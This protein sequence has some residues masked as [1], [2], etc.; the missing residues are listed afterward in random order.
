MSK[1]K[2]SPEWILAR[3]RE[4]L[5]GKNTYRNIAKAHGIS[6]SSLR[7]WVRKYRAWGERAF[8]ETPGYRSYTKEFK[9]M[10]VKE[11]LS[12][13]RTPESV[14][15][16]HHISDRTVLLGWISLYN[17]GKELK[18]YLPN[19]EVRMPEARRV[20]TREERKEIV[21]YCIVHNK[22]YKGTAALYHVSYMQVYSWVKKYEDRGDEGLRD[23]RGHRKKDDELDEFEKLRRENARL[24]RQLEDN[25]M[26]SELLKKVRALKRR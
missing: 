24:K 23:R 22:D 18:D 21:R 9:Q 6:D 20:T 26:L 12:G 13:N 7:G 8:D 16:A 15:L 17:A 25:Y 3:V 19:R 11:A 10:C 5:A 2:H 1:K 14:A 4:Y